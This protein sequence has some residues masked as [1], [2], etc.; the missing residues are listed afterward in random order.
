[1]FGTVNENGV[2]N[3]CIDE[4]LMSL[5]VENKILSEKSGKED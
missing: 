1:M 2:W 5:C 3:I 4:E